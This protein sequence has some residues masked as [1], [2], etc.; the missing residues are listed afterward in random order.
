MKSFPTKRE[1]IEGLLAVIDPVRYAQTR[2]Y[3]SGAVTYLSPYISRGIFTTRDVF[4]HLKNQSLTWQEVEKLVQELAWRDYFQWVWKRLGAGINSDIKQAQFPI[5]NQEI[6]LAFLEAE[7]GID[8]I[9]TGIKALYDTG[10]MHNHVRM[11]TASLACNI[12]QIHW[13]EPA[14]WM[15]YHLLDADW[16]SNACSWQWVA[17]SFSNKKYYANQENINRYCKTHQQ[18]TYLDTSYEELNTLSVPGQLVQV[19]QFN[20]KT[21]LPKSTTDFKIDQKLPVLIYN[22][23]NLDF[24][25]WEH[26]DCN[27]VLLLEP[28]IFKEYPISGHS[29]QFMLELS[30]NIPDIQ[31]FV[32]SFEALKKHC[33][34]AAIVFKEHPLNAYQGQEEARRFLTPPTHK[35]FNSF[36]GFWKTIEK[37]LKADFEEC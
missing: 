34:E 29:M 33:G 12:A 26:K 11:Y 20:L 23:Y 31:I 13:R 6:P 18:D 17:G 30:K 15:Y 10:Y 9:D 5:R 3:V 14:R 35:Q 19:G 24:R 7:T 25:W 22:W 16:A 32:G 21:E 2:N 4:N 8:G 37:Q 1:D 28:E 36:F 27:R